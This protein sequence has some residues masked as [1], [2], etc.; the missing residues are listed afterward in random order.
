MTNKYFINKHLQH[1]QRVNDQLSAYPM[2]NNPNQMPVGQIM[3]LEERRRLEER[4]DRES[5]AAGFKNPLTTT[6]QNQ[7]LRD[8]YINDNNHSMYSSEQP[9]LNSIQNPMT[10]KYAFSSLLE[11]KE[12]E[13]PIDDKQVSPEERAAA[14]AALKP[15]GCGPSGWKNYVIPD[16]V[17][18]F[19]F[20]PACNNH[21]RNYSTL[22]FGFDRANQL[23]YDDMMKIVLT[24]TEPYSRR[25]LVGRSHARTYR[26]FVMRHGKSYY[27]EAQQKAYICKFGRK[28]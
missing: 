22:E 7:S 17:G 6:N 12:D 16:V 4:I 10:R 15:N 24:E 3:L 21:D 18:G 27:D 14:C 5:L 13:S 28:P 23:F 20:K 19:N 26:N 1:L 9:F 8:N 11:E 25:F 2:T